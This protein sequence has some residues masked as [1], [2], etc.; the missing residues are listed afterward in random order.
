MGDTGVREGSVAPA[1]PAARIGRY[2]LRDTLGQGSTG[3]V[4][5]AWDPFAESEVALKVFDARSGS[6][7]AADDEL[8]RQFMSEAAL[9]GKLSHPHIA[10]ILEASAGADPAYIAMEYVSGGT[11]KPY[12]AADRLLRADRLMQIAFKTC[13]ALDYASKKGIVHGDL[14][15]ANLLLNGDTHVKV[16]DFGAARLRESRGARLANLGSP[17]Y[18]SPE[19]IAEGEQGPQSDMFSMGVSLYELLTGQRPFVGP[20]L[21]AILEQ[22]MRR[23]P[24]APSTVRPNIPGRIDELVLRM[25]AK[26]PAERHASWADLALD[27]AE[28]GRLGMAQQEVPDSE[29]FA[30][31]RA[32]PL[33]GSLDDGGIWELVHAGQWRRVAGGTPVVREGEHGRSLFFLARGQA[34][35]TRLGRLLGV[36]RG[37]EYFGEMAYVKN[38]AVPRQASVETITDVLLAEFDPERL[39]RASLGCRLQLTHALLDS[40]VDRLQLA[41][42]RLVPTQT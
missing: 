26:R 19:R 29:R 41:N 37:G 35:V 13:G 7:A 25:L 28:V 15:P 6:R 27:I 9:V 5:R 38:G 12:S 34:K 11:L 36:L 14:K 23:D 31:L 40:V 21:P 17:A 3:R 8:A 22:I 32:L 20:D 39:H 16:A 4:Y 1:P 10:S 24:P 42:A 33:L 2:E 30:A 18:M